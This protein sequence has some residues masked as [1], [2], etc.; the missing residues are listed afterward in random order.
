MALAKAP[1]T[2][3]ADAAAGF[4]GAGDLQSLYALYAA[5]TGTVG[6]NGKT[7]NYSANLA[8]QGITLPGIPSGV[9][10]AV[11]NV[12]TFSGSYFIQLD[13]N[14]GGV[15]TTAIPEPGTLA[16]L[17]AGLIGLLCYA[18]RKRK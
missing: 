2:F 16:L 11:N 15:Y 5:T 1:L 7:W 3:T 9:A 18:W 8:T 10:S 12:G 4:Y 6:I 14:G 13:A 17:A